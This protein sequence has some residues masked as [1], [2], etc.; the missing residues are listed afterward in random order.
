M[1]EADPEAFNLKFLLKDH[2]FVI[3]D[4]IIDMELAAFHCKV[5]F[6][7]ARLNL[8]I[9]ILAPSTILATIDDEVIC[10]ILSNLLREAKSALLIVV[11][12]DNILVD[13]CLAVHSGVNLILK[14]YAAKRV[15]S[16]HG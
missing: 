5:L 3:C 15:I 16:L 10:R 4:K 2:W 1:L 8:E 13:I 9:D 7:K 12:D 11:I 6:D 14:H